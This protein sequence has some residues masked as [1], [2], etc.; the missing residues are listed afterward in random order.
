MKTFKIKWIEKSNKDWV[1]CMERESIV[2]A[3]TEDAAKFLLHGAH[4]DV[5]IDK[6]EGKYVIKNETMEITSVEE[7]VKENKEKE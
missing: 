4:K 5:T 6:K 1:K 7:V 3:E 2:T